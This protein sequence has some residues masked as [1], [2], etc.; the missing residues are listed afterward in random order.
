VRICLCHPAENIDEKVVTEMQCNLTNAADGKFTAERKALFISGAFSKYT[1]FGKMSA[2]RFT[3]RN[4]N[5][6]KLR[7]FL[8]AGKTGAFGKN[9]EQLFTDIFIGRKDIYCC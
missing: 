3:E 2:F 1:G 8:S 9:P 7:T 6:K 4:L 5:Y